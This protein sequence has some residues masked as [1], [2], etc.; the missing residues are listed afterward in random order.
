MVGVIG[1]LWLFPF[2][3]P[4]WVHTK[5]YRDDLPKARWRTSLST[6]RGKWIRP[7]SGG[8]GLKRHSVHAEPRRSVMKRRQNKKKSVMSK[9]LYP[10]F[11]ISTH[12]IL[13]L[14]TSVRRPIPMVRGLFQ[15]QKQTAYH[16][17]RS[18]HWCGQCQYAMSGY[19]K[20]GYKFLLITDLLRRFITDLLG[21]A[22]DVRTSLV[23]LCT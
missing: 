6:P 23:R 14:T 12:C 21:L 22:C 13:T 10:I 20:N 5:Y 8:N 18:T 11:F 3:F 7:T 1:G 17:Y 15:L 9:N 16:G 2:W 4:F 19:K